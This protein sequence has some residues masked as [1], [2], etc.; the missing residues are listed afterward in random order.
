MPL[1]RKRRVKTLI[2]QAAEPEKMKKIKT[3]GQVNTAPDK[4]VSLSFRM[5]K[6]IL[7]MKHKPAEAGLPPA[8]SITVNQC[9]TD[10]IQ[11]IQTAPQDLSRETITPMPDAHRSVTG[12][13]VPPLPLPIEHHPSRGIKP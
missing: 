8:D 11:P 10:N 4:T 2:R 7:R 13:A 3:R 6:S 12:A 5:K 1:R 9:A